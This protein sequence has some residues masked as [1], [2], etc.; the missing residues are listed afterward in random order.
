MIETAIVLLRDI[1]RVIVCSSSDFHFKFAKVRV[2]AKK[3][4]SWNM[5]QAV[6][7]HL[8]ANPNATAKETLAALLAENPKLNKGSFNVAFYTSRRKSNKKRVVGKRSVS[9]GMTLTEI[10][11]VRIAQKLVNSVGVADAIQLV[12]ALE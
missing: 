5:S 12:K 2:M 6:R 8:A 11:A 1:N 9:T 7:D 3:S 4:S 10:D